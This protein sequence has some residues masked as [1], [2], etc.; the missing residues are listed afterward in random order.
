[1]YE[2]LLATIYHELDKDL[3]QYLLTPE[4]VSLNNKNELVTTIKA[5]YY[6]VRIVNSKF[7]LAFVID[8]EKPKM[9]IVTIERDENDDR[10]EYSFKPDTYRELEK[11]RLNIWNLDELINHVHKLVLSVFKEFFGAE[12]NEFKS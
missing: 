5:S 3:R 11:L 12:H 2:K 1:M 8:T 4:I 10:I 7:H 6:G 9:S